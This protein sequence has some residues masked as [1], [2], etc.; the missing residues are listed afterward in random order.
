MQGLGVQS[1]VEEL[2]SHISCGQKTKEKQKQC[3]NKFNE[4]FKSDPYQEQ[5]KKKSKEKDL[6]DDKE[7][8]N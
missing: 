1:L 7:L 5:Q 6:N 3:C 8:I 2:R 4:D